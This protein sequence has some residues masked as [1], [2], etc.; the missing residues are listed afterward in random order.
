MPTR[1]KLSST[2][3]KGTLE[4][5]PPPPSPPSSLRPCLGLCYL[6]SHTPPRTVSLLGGALPS[7]LQKPSHTVGPLKCPA[8]PAHITS[9]AERCPWLASWFGARRVLAC[10]RGAPLCPGWVGAL[11]VLHLHS[12]DANAC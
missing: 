2:A 7:S 1:P 12:A 6:L 3:F 8:E 10:V 9:G 11:L 5:P 4:V